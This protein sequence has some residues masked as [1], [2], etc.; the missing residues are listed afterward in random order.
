[1]IIGWSVTKFMFLEEQKSKN[2]KNIQ[3]NNFSNDLVVLNM[4]ILKTFFL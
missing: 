4:E 2:I 3:A 1:M